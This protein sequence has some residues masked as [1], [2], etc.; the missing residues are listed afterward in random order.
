MTTD[1]VPQPLAKDVERH[2]LTMG[3]TGHGESQMLQQIAD[4]RGITVEELLASEKPSPDAAAK[5]AQRRKDE[6]LKFDKRSRAVREAYW[7]HTDDKSSEFSNFY[8]CILQAAG[9]VDFEQVTLEKVKALFMA[10]PHG[11]VAEGINWGFGDS[12][13]RDNLHSF[14]EE[15]KDDVLKAIATCA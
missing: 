5:E 8:D 7:E 12:V 2:M 4:M 3:A 1:H 13:V 15:N 6:E 9:Y 10:I 14:C 11:L